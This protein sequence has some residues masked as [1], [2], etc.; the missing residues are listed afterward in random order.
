[1]V[2]FI[3]LWFGYFRFG[4]AVRFS[5][6]FSMNSPT[7][8]IQNK[9]TALYCIIRLLQRFVNCSFDYAGRTGSKFFQLVNMWM[10]LSGCS[11]IIGN[12]YLSIFWCIY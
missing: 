3:N 6:W 9:P 5:L 12:N 7:N 10:L 8:H 1:M 2:R 4:L 11:I